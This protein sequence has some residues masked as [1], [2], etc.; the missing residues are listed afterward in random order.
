MGGGFDLG[1]EK[2][3]GARGVEIV[4]ELVSQGGFYL[5]ICAGAYFA[6]D[7]VQFDLNGPLQ[8]L[9]LWILYLRNW[10][11]FT[12]WSYLRIPLGLKVNLQF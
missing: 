6:T 5:G 7:F 3:L 4:R 8:V 11:K 12:N 10:S 2:M 9:G 1:Y